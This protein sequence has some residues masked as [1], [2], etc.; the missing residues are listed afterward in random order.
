H[1][2]STIKNADKI[3]VM[4]KGEIKEIGK[5]DELIERGGLYYGLVKAQELKKE[6]DETS[7]IIDDKS[8]KLNLKRLTTKGSIT[9]SIKLT[10]EEVEK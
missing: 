10:D 2:L 8:N 1:R 7:V 9:K 4:S 3:V 6:E 5:H